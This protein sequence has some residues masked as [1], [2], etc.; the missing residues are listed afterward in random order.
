MLS[1]LVFYITNYPLFDV[2]RKIMQKALYIFMFSFAPFYSLRKYY[3]FKTTKIKIG[4]NITVIG[5]AYD[6]LIGNETEIYNNVVFEFNR[7]SKIRIGMKCIISYGV[8]I[9]CQKEL[10]IGNLCMIGEYSSIRDTT[11]DYCSSIIRNGK[12]YSSSIII[13]DNVWIG[14]GCIILPGT[15]IGNG[16]VVGANSTIKGILNENTIYAGNPAKEI[17]KRLVPE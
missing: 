11:H 1:K 17:K 13:G 10:Q 12:D 7:N 9:S 15:V 4:R 3:Y 14:R 2:A 8:V 6:I 5:Q 16:V